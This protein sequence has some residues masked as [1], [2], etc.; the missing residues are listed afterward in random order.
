VL[1]IQTTKQGL[2]ALV[3]KAVIH[4]RMT[5]FLSLVGNREEVHA[6]WGAIG[7]HDEVQI[8]NQ[9]VRRPWRDI[10]ARFSTLARGIS[11]LV[12]WS[13]DEDYFFGPKK[14][15]ADWL[16]QSLGLP[17]LPEWVPFI[18]DIPE[19]KETNT[20]VWTHNTYGL[21]LS[22][23]ARQEV[24]AFIQEALKKGNLPLPDGL[25]HHPVLVAEKVLVTEARG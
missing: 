1:T 11:H 13:Q 3:H 4:Q 24:R 14:Q 16:A 19:I 9:F 17:V 15:L 6:L 5:V 8:G 2:Q 25:K 7:G 10:K 22:S 18:E 21:Y 23:S 12:I 20:K